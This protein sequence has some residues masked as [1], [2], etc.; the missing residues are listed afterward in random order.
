MGVGEALVNVRRQGHRP[1]AV[2]GTFD[3]RGELQLDDTVALVFADDGVKI[4]H[5]VRL[6]RRDRD[7]LAVAKPLGRLGESEPPVIQS[8]EQQELHL[9]A[10][11][12]NALQPSP[13]TPACC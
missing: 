8:T 13:R 2:E 3:R 12:P 7:R 4:A 10:G 9:P 6:L 1:D 5:H 11:G